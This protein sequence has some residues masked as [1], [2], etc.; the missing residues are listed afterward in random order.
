MLASQE[1]KRLNAFAGGPSF[2]SSAAKDASG[3]AAV[4]SAGGD[5]A[6]SA[7]A[8]PAPAIIAARTIATRKTEARRPHGCPPNPRPDTLIDRRR[9]HNPRAEEMPGG[10]PPVG[11]RA[12]ECGLVAAHS[13]AG[14]TG[15]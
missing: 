3:K 15:N 10:V 14:Q 6:S 2:S 7:V 12:R 4:R 13:D 8:A 5:A 1:K 9:W 11:P